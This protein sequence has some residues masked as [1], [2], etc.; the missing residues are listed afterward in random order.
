MYELPYVNRALCHILLNIRKADLSSFR[1][2]IPYLH[3]LGIRSGAE[4]V[5]SE[6]CKTSSVPLLIRL[7]R[8]SAALPKEAS[9]LFQTELR[10]TAL[11]NQ[12]LYQK[13]YRTVPE[14]QRRFK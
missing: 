11:Y 6:L 1:E 12:L 13:G 10:A 2:S 14:L 8:D 4:P 5:L 9:Q 7:L 3:V